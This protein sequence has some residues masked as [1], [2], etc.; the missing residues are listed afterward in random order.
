MRPP[1]L[2]DD[3]DGMNSAHGA[4]AATL[5]SVNLRRFEPPL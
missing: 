1:T 3:D 2:Q 5:T 4:A